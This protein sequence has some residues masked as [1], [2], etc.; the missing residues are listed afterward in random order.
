MPIVV[1]SIAGSSPAKLTQAIN[2]LLATLAGQRAE[3]ARLDESIALSL[4]ELGYGG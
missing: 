3:A 1:A 4:A 2:A